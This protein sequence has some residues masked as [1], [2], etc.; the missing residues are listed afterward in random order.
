MIAENVAT[1]V[2]W[3]QIDGVDFQRP[4][5]VA[6]LALIGYLAVVA[7]GAAVAFARRDIAATA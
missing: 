4:P 2:P 6:L 1:F 3:K 5:I 7:A